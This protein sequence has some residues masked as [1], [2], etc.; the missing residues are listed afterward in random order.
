MNNL[1]KR[2]EEISNILDNYRDRDF[3]QR[4][5][6]TD[7]SKYLYRMKL[8]NF[9]NM[10]HVLDAGCG[11]GQ[12]SIALSMFNERVSAIDFSKQRIL[13][14]D[15]ITRYFNQT[16]I[17][18]YVGSI[19]KL[20]FKDNQFDAIYSYSA[21]YLTD[22]QKTLYEF[23]R[24]LKKG[25]KLYISTNDFGWY[26]YNII[27]NHNPSSDY[28][29]RKNAIM[30]LLNSVIFKF[31]KNKMLNC[32]LIMPKNKTIKIL[33]KIGFKNIVSS[34]DGCLR[35]KS[36]MSTQQFYKAKYFIFNNVYEVLGVK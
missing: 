27:I 13:A 16:N 33:Q 1:N 20:P 34:A 23:H 2:I 35:Y 28:N 25:G 21:I 31:T 17:N 15:T 6:K 8:I 29:P 30:T 19:E 22:Y 14:A 3:F 32:D 5:F 4:I 7:F 26:L 36:D 9:K 18:Y 11:F 12:W 10:H 24:V